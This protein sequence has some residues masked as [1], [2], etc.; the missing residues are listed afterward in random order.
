MKT[1][2]L[3]IL[4]LS[5]PLYLNGQKISDKIHA[6]VLHHNLSVNPLNISLFQQIGIT[7]EYRPG[8]LGFGI[9]LGYIYP[10]KNEYSNWFIAGPTKYG[11]LGWYSG[12]F[13]I[14]QVNLYL[15]RQKDF[16]QGG[17]LYL[18]LKFVYKHMQLDTT[19][20]TAWENFGDGYHSFRKMTD[21][22]NIYG[23]FIDAGYRYFLSHFFFD[24]NLGIGP[25]WLNHNMKIYGNL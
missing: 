25:T 8:K 15:T 14:P 12:W 4:I 22:V 10:N 13:V 2:I 23:G 1:V 17:V 16:D 9:T 18:A 3:I 7:Y 11:S 20:V 21:K 24:L 6:D 19:T 5:A